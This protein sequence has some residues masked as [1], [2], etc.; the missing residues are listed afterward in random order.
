[1]DN[2]SSSVVPAAK[3]LDMVDKLETELERKLKAGEIDL[4]LYAHDKRAL[5][6]R[7]KKEWASLCRAMGWP[8]EYN[9]LTYDP[10]SMVKPAHKPVSAEFS[11]YA[12]RDTDEFDSPPSEPVEPLDPAII[13]RRRLHYLIFW[14]WVLVLSG[15]YLGFG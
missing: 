11:L 3:R 6:L 2:S 7:R 5:V 13:K 1:M 12:V 10:E 14:I 8:I 9:P 4:T 15:V